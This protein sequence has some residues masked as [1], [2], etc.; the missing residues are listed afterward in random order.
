MDFE[1]LLQKIGLTKRQAKIYLACL[2]FGPIGLT[3]LSQKIHEKKTTVFDTAKSLIEKNF[4]SKTKKDN[5]NVFVA[6]K[7]EIIEN[8]FRNNLDVFKESLSALN[9]IITQNSGQPLVKYYQDKSG[10]KQIF[11]DI[12]NCQDKLS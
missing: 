11:E 4:L 12:L 2:R 10:L 8:I 9:S 7:P 1:S 6:E 5:K 3:D